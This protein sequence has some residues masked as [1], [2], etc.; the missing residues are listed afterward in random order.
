M[1][2]KERISRRISLKLFQLSV[3]IVV[4]SVS[5]LFFLLI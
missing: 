2:K 5:W 3:S 4:V 1:N